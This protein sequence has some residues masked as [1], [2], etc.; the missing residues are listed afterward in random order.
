MILWEK[1][2]IYISSIFIDKNGVLQGNLPKRKYK[3]VVQLN[4][5]NWAFLSWWDNV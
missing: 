4:T 2:E 5:R 1:E 3:L